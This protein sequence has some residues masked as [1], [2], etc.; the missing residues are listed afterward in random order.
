MGMINKPSL[1]N[2]GF[3]FHLIVV[4]GLFFVIS[5][6]A[7]LNLPAYWSRE[8]YSHGILIPFLAAFIGWHVLVRDKPE[9]KPSWLGLPVLIFSLLLSILSELAAFE[10]LLNYSFIVALFGISLGFFGKKYTYTLFPA[11]AFLFFAAPLPHIVYGNLSIKM[12]LVSSTLGTN[13]IQLFGFSVYRDGNIIDLGHMKLQVAEACNG[14][15][16]LFPLM[17]LGYLMAYLM[18]DKWWK[19]ILVFASVVPITIVMNSLR[20]AIVGVTVNLWGEDMAEGVLH[21]FEGFVVF[22]VCLTMLMGLAWVL[23]HIWGR[24][25]FRDEF[26]ALP[27]GKIFPSKVA[28]TSIIQACLIVSCAGALLFNSDLIKNR[29]EN[30]PITPD[31]SNF[32]A[33][34]GEWHGKRDFLTLEE[35]D[36][37]DLTD[38]WMADYTKDASDLPVNLYVAYYNNQ[39]MRANIHIPLNCILGGGWEVDLQSSM[40]VETPKGNIPVKRLVIR[41]D[42]EAGVVYY[43]L[44]QRGRKISDP[45]KAKLFLVWDSIMLH[46]TD[47]ALVRVT[48]P[49]AKSET[50]KDADERLQY[51][52]QK[53]YPEVEEFIPGK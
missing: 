2:I 46:R 52:L 53:A 51:F 5:S 8:T 4:I 39:R 22:G 45:L 44:E 50:P 11:L 19:R 32:P 18:E 38:Y 23:M 36:A 14:L 7:L 16:Y 24:G 47:G 43:W 37:L 25:R 48:T 21:S 6:N 34:I 17:S 20:I 15:R 13:L 3:I 10:A 40:S 30:T 42:T 41:K 35:R 49:L 31:F 9:I 27:K 33:E 28:V 1:Q 26:L 12:Q 29:L